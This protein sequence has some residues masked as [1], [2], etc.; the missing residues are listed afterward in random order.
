MAKLY[1]TTILDPVEAPLG[2]VGTPS[3]GVPL[4]QGFTVPSGKTGTISGTLSVTGSTTLAGVTVSGALSVTTVTTGNV[5]LD[6]GNA[7]GAALTIGTNDNFQV[8]FETN[9]TP[10]GFLAAS[11]EWNLGASGFTGAHVV[12][13][14]IQFA[15]GSAPN[16]N[17]S[18]LSYHSAGTFSGT[19]TGFTTSPSLTVYYVRIGN[20]VILTAGAAAFTSNATTLSMTGVPTHL[21]PTTSKILSHIVTDNGTNAQGRADVTA[22]STINFYVTAAAGA[23]TNTGSKGFPG[24]TIVYTIS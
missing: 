22:S 23:F 15:N 10:R 2:I 8:N 5:I 19:L 17:N 20:M 13:G 3:T 16:T 4:P 14:A 6:G 7:R 18:A 21:T 1:G 9:G 12:N 11:G 24:L